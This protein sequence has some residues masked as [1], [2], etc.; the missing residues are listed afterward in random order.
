M[1]P[2]EKRSWPCQS[3]IWMLELMDKYKGTFYVEIY[4]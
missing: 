4:K 3:L 1:L 2:L